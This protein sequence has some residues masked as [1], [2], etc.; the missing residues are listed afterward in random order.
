MLRCEDNSIYTGI[1]TD[2]KRRIKEHISKNDKCAKYTL[3]HTVKKIE[4]AWETENRAFA[5]TL[6]YH[7]KKL[8]K[9]DKEELIKNASM[10][11][12]LLGNKIDAAKYK[13]LEI[14][15]LYIDD[16]GYLWEKRLYPSSRHPETNGDIFCVTD[17]MYSRIDDPSQGIG[18]FA[19]KTTTIERGGID[20]A[21]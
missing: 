17:D 10:I 12:S 4:S 5:S 1:T 14:A 9:K 13:V 8:S 18:T 3:N 21:Q 6:E 11:S 7:I 2:L 15:G 16:K 19:L 20:I